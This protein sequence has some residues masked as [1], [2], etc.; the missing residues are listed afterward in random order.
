MHAA[1]AVAYGRRSR[2]MIEAPPAVLHD[3]RDALD[4]LGVRPRRIVLIS[5]LERHKGRRCAY[6]VDTEDGRTLKARHFE[7]VGEADRQ[8]VLREG[9]EAAFAPVLAQAGR[10]LL[11]E[12][13]DGVPLTDRDPDSYAGV[14]GA[15]LGRL[16]ARPL[17]VDAP[18]VFE[19]QK[20]AAAAL[21]DLTI[22]ASAEILDAHT[23]A[24]LEAGIRQRDPG[25][26]SAAL[27]HTDFCAENMLID[28]HGL[29]RVIDNEQ[30]TVA[31][32][33]YD[34]GR[35]FDRWPMSAAAWASFRV[36]YRSAAVRPADALGFWKLVAALAGA[37]LRH[38]RTPARLPATLVLLRRFAA[39]ER[40]VDS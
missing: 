20:W 6:R 31:P 22:L 25:T 33:G 3:V 9:L 23:V 21:S 35:T 4:R 18:A 7:S 38:Q 17:A 32:A 27:V 19:T 10:V 5:P 34:L 8:R 36:A 2:T 16:H 14:G 39:D 26:A 29:L 28:T 30:F 13:I 37:R 24:V 1:V 11:E 12:W 15:L 40:F